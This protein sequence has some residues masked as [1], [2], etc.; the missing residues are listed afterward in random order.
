MK[1]GFTCSFMLWAVKSTNFDESGVLL[2]VPVCCGPVNQRI[3]MKL[4]FTYL[5]LCTVGWQTYE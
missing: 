4:G 1:L 5:F 2:P 3:V